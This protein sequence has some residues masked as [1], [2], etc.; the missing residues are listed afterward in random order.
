VQAQNHIKS[1]ISPEDLHLPLGFGLAM[2]G[3][4]FD[5][6]ISQF[7]VVNSPELLFFPGPQEED[8]VAPRLAR[9]QADHQ[10]INGFLRQ[11]LLQD[12]LADG[13][14]SGPVAHTAHRKGQQN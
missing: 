10:D 5:E 6:E 12:G 1:Q 8:S 13:L 11:H 2:V 9:L 7:R 14:V 4:I 3:D